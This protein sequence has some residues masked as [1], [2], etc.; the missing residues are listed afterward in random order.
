MSM[1][2]PLEHLQRKPSRFS[3][4]AA[5]RLL[6]L[7]GRREDPGAV[8][9]FV[10][11]ISLAQPGAEVSAVEPITAQRKR[12]RLQTAMIGL[13][14]P[15]GTMPRWYTEQI[16]LSVRNRAPAVA[17]FFD[18]LAQR[19]MAAFVEAG[20]KYRP[21]LAAERGAMTSLRDATLARTAAAR[22]IDAVATDPVASVLLA[23]SGFGTDWLLDRLD[24]GGSVIQHYAGFYATQARSSE[25]L[26]AII[27]DWLGR[28]VSIIEFA[29]LWLTLEPSEQSRMP[30]GRISGQFNQLGRDCAVGARAFDQQA[31]FILRIGPLDRAGFEALL[32]DQPTLRRLVSLIRAYVGMESD[33]A[34]N[35]VLDQAAIPIMRLGGADA[36]RLSWTGWL[37]RP[38]AS[39]TGGRHADDAL[40][41]ASLIERHS[42]PITKLI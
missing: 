13:I 31:R 27:S 11:D 4:R 19:L 17:Q 5:T 20:A 32:P 24:A 28:Q 8:I 22:G 1:L 29:G 6:W 16:A 37:P 40:F 42:K 18:L 21:H 33:F 15:S 38:T 41:P 36:P 35:L 26:A 39:L 9:R 34:I 23:L 7:A 30:K 12:A 10:A 2:S 25:R 14:G 3:F